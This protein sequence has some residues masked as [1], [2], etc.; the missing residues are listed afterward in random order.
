MTRW[1]AVAVLFAAGAPAQTV[2]LDDTR[3][4]VLR[5]EALSAAPSIL[6]DYY[7]PEALAELPPVKWRID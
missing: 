5:V 2:F 6:Y 1:L 3:S 7:N 4:Q